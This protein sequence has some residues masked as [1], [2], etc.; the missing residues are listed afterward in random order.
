VER[1]AVYHRLVP[2]DG[3]GKAGLVHMSSSFIGVGSTLT[4]CTTGREALSQLFE[5]FEKIHHAFGRA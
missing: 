2:L 5:N 4:D 3:G 1:H